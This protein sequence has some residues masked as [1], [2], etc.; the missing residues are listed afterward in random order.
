MK[1]LI[2]ANGIFLEAQRVHF[3][4]IKEALVESTSLSSELLSQLILKASCPTFVEK[5]KIPDYSFFI[6]AG[7]DQVLN[8]TNFLL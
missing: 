4:G 5:L 6:S 1:A 2:G 7:T 8:T 3:L